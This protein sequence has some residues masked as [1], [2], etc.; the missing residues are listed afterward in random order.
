MAN[1]NI[2]KT[3]TKIKKAKTVNYESVKQHF[4]KKKNVASEKTFN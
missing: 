3:A 1:N 2:K 4:K